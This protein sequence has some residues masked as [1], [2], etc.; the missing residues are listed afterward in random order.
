MN[1]ICAVYC[2]LSR[3][4]KNSIGESESIQ[5]Q[6]SMLIKYALERNW[7]IY[8]I[9]CDEDRSGIDGE[10]PEFNE[11]LSDGEKGK[12][13]LILCKSQSRFTRDM[14]LVEKYIH[15][16]FLTWGIRFVAVADNADSIV[17]GNKKAR[18][19]NGLV[20]EWYL[21]DLSENIKTVLTHKRENGL[22]IGSFALYGYEK[23]ERDKG[24]LLIDRDAAEV[25]K[26]IYRLYL[27]GYGKQ[28]IADDLNGKGIPSPARYK[29]LKHPSYKCGS[30]TGENIW[31]KTAVSRI[32]KN[33]IYTGA[34]V[35]GKNR[36]I[37]YKSDKLT[38]MPASEWIRA[39][40]THE[41]IISMSVFERTQKMLEKRSRCCKDGK[42]HIFSGLIICAHC[43]CGLRKISNNYKNGSTVYLKCPKCGN[44]IRQALIENAVKERL[45]FFIKKY[46]ENLPVIYENEAE[47][48][49]EIK[50][51][52]KALQNQ[53]KLREEA[54]KLLYLDRAA[55]IMTRTQFSEMNESF[56]SDKKNAENKIAELNDKLGSMA[57]T[58]D[59]SAE[60]E[61]NRDAL[62]A[63]IRKIEVF[64][65]EKDKHSQRVE[66]HWCF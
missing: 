66:I 50:L 65:T 6:K 12:F 51:R 62:A 24:K 58:A 23:S 53:V 26:E 63:F 43:K 19:I 7:Q 49:N 41:P 8:K 38:S 16:K 10:R 61:I 31:S 60:I 64:Q 40:N 3:E 54:I 42:V 25:V 20:N 14:E 1:W 28:R 2:R 44:Y 15:G 36:K 48:K 55:G 21:E 4:D 35:Q 37:S 33:E 13:N 22:H 56:L 46:G 5:N 29:A 18:Q 39:Y 34:M 32:L 17:K 52:I 45:D 27:E 47:L 30:G 11:M 59:K 9:Y 57:K